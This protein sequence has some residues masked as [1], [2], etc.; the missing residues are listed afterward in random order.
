MKKE[1]TKLPAKFEPVKRFTLKLKPTAELRCSKERMGRIAHETSPKLTSLARGATEADLDRLRDDL[2]RPL[3]EEANDLTLLDSLRR[4]AHE[5]AAA[6]WLTP[7]PL[8][9]LPALLEEKTQK[10]SAHVARQR[11]ILRK[12]QRS[13]QVAA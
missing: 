13:D 4:A 2:L 1:T 3:L 8:L 5:A 7:F 6:A 12:T 9:F 11:A 10:A